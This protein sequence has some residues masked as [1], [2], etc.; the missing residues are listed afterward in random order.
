[1]MTCRDV[2]GFLDDYLERALPWRTRLRFE[3]HL[4]MCSECRRYIARYRR[5]IELGQRLL[6]P[7][8]ERPAQPEVP[9]DLVQAILGS[10][11]REPEPDP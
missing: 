1:M 6:S 3:F 11:A 10:I 7:E 8:P 4:R 5:A 9:E 2:E